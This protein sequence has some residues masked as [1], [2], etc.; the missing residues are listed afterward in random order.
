MNLQFYIYIILQFHFIYI[1]IYIYICIYWRRGAELRYFSIL[2]LLSA[3]FK[4]HF[5]QQQHLISLENISDMFTQ[6]S[7]K[8]W[9]SKV[10]ASRFKMRL[11]VEPCIRYQQI[12][13]FVLV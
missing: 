5:Q 1:Y 8:R 4:T 11:K 6:N 13:V 9:F 3:R 10:L 2:H 7:G 12:F